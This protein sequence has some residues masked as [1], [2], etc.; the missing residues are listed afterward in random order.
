MKTFLLKLCSLLV[1][2][3]GAL[4]IAYELQL[5]PVTQALFDAYT[6]AMDRAP[7]EP[8]MLRL[9]LGVVLGVVGVVSLAPSPASRSKRRVVTIPTERGEASVQLD[10]V[11]K[12]LTG[13]LKRM[14]EVKKAKVVARP[15]K[16]RRRAIIDAYVTLKQEPDLAARHTVNLVTEH[17]TNSAVQI[18][19]LED[20]AE[21]RLH[22]DS[23]TVNTKQAAKA[24]AA[25]HPELEQKLAERAA[26][27]ATGAT[28]LAAASVLPVDETEE[29]AVVDQEVAVEEPT[30]VDDAEA[31]DV[32]DAVDMEVSE[33]EPED[34]DVTDDSDED[35]APLSAG[36]DADEIIAPL[37]PLTD[38]DDLRPALGVFETENDLGLPPLGDGEAESAVSTENRS[39]PDTVALFELADQDTEDVAEE[40]AGAEDASWMVPDETPHAHEPSALESEREAFWKGDDDPDPYHSEAA[41]IGETAFS[42]VEEHEI[43][44]ALPDDAAERTLERLDLMAA[45]ELEEKED[46]T[47]QDALPGENPIGLERSPEVET[48][49]APDDAAPVSDFVDPGFAEAAEK[50]ETEP[51]PKPKRWGFF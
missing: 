20:L 2:A 51:R 36:N 16:D 12:V 31:D 10:A 9:V 38:D 25:K 3:A 39:E 14:P 48:E 44:V 21:V 33:E 13:I 35:T 8:E 50:S 4:L 17:I 27:G 15:T 18:L 41:E 24:I 46:D 26:T 42:A 19:G 34:L 6:Q 28:A 40:P 23:M 7:L 43:H 11:A 1:L 49:S 37:P 22:V 29:F 30:I 32:E 45:S 47:D 5:T